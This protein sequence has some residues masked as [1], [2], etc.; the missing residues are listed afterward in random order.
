MKPGRIRNRGKNRIAAG[1]GILR[2]N[3][4]MI[5]ARLRSEIASARNPE[6]GT[7][8]FSVFICIRY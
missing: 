5:A 1:M 2:I 4:T 7:R 8:I 6:V 3:S